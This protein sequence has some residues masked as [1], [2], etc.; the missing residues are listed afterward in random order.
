[1]CT[2]STIGTA[3]TTNHPIRRPASIRRHIATLTA[4]AG[5]HRRR[6]P[7]WLGRRALLVPAAAERG[8]RAAV[9]QA[10]R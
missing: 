9:G 7:L 1:V 5:T 8:L 4:T 6:R 2:I 3:A 10:I